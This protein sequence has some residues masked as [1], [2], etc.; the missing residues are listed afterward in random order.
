MLNNGKWDIRP[1]QFDKMLFK[2]N[3]TFIYRISLQKYNVYHECVY[4][5]VNGKCLVD[6]AFPHGSNKWSIVF[7]TTAYFS[8]SH[9]PFERVHLVYTS[10]SDIFIRK[11]LP[12]LSPLNF[13]ISCRVFLK[14]L[15][16]IHT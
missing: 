16:M 4:R 3:S 7:C 14:F 1:R 8:L 10:A 11:R 5:L 15:S 12:Y 13:S 2:P 6:N 9:R